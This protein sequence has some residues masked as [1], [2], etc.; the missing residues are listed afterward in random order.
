MLRV[1]PDKLNFYVGMGYTY[2]EG[3]MSE[4][5]DNLSKYNLN[6]KLGLKANK[7]LRFDF[8][9][10]VMLTITKRPNAQSNYIL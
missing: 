10:N 9:N 4:V 8:S 2:Q 1:V 6:T 7:W 3:L 5:E